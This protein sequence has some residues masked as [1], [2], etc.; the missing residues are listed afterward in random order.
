M[1]QI[2]KHKYKI[3]KKSFLKTIFFS[4]VNVLCN[5][6]LMIMAT[7]LLGEIQDKGVERVKEK[8]L[9]C[10]AIYILKVYVTIFNNKTTESFKIA[11]QDF[12]LQISAAITKLSQATLENREF[13]NK[14]HLARQLKQEDVKNTNNLLSSY[15]NGTML[16]LMSIYLVYNIP[17]SVLCLLGLILVLHYFIQYQKKETS[18]IWMKYQNNV[19]EAREYHQILIDRPHCYERN[20][21]RFFPLV[22]NKY[23]HCA[24]EGI[25]KNKKEGKKRFVLDTVLSLVTIVFVT[26]IIYLSMDMFLKGKI[27]LPQ[28]F[29]LISF[30]LLFSKMI[31]DEMY[32]NYDYR[33]YRACIDAVE[34]IM[35]KSQ[36]VHAKKAEIE[37][38]VDTIE[39][40]DVWFQYPNTDQFVLKGV[41]YK[42]CSDQTYAI[43]GRNGAGKSTLIKLITGLYKPTKGSLLI[44]G[45]N[46]CELSN[47]E[48]KRIFGV[49]FQNPCCYPI[50][51]KENIIFDSDVCAEDFVDKD[52]LKTI[53]GFKNGID[54]SVSP[55]DENM[56]TLSG[57]Q[58]QKIFFSRVKAKENSV[59]IL[60][61]PTSHLDPLSELDFYEQFRSLS[62]QKVNIFISHRMGI[63]NLADDILVIDDGQIVENGSAECLY[64]K[65][66]LF[67]EM[68]NEQKFS[69]IRG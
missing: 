8:I 34:E 40:K 50:S 58:W 23:E 33:N 63:I 32:K 12:Y 69:Y 62:N 65:G 45:E 61:E 49:L 3:Y 9:L 59:L 31:R 1:F 5:F 44:N 11:D 10:I 47:E 48:R 42:F 35:R 14:T 56:V 2:S 37:G 24:K 15:G 30:A 68:F 64:E 4:E 53:K 21:F 16:I 20:L 18:E 6:I 54:T 25:G 19:R 13:Q 27:S 55:F 22:N 29:V 52:L 43:L 51:I 7:G 41:N 38:A 67:H 17:V 39:L 66:G 36:N 28:V 26:S 46:A 57:G 60:D